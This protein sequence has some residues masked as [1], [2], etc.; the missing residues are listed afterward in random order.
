MNASWINMTFC[1]RTIQGGYEVLPS[2][3]HRVGN[4]IQSSAQLLAL[5]PVPPAP[6]QALQQRNK[7][8][9]GPR[10]LEGPRLPVAERWSTW[11]KKV[12]GWTWGWRKSLFVRPHSVIS[13]YTLENE[14]EWALL[15]F[16][17][18]SSIYLSPLTPLCN[19]GQS[20]MVHGDL[21]SVRSVGDKGENKRCSKPQLYARDHAKSVRIC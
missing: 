2:R 16:W 5:L 19:T 6:L 13:S 10:K 17:K 18:D 21:S 20:L 8:E 7:T 12:D 15:P 3:E 1:S 4:E 9:R 14:N 11:F